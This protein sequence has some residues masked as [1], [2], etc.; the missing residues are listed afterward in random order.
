MFVQ[1][2]GSEGREEVDVGSMVLVSV[3]VRARKH[4]HARPRVFCF[5]VSKW[6][7][8][9]RSLPFS[10]RGHRLRRAETATT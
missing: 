8:L 5:N 1:L 7:L 9:F 3:C 6:F 4:V 2:H 10:G